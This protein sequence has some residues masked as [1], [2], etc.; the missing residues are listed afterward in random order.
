[1]KF[2][3]KHFLTLQELS[4]DELENLIAGIMDAKKKDYF[5]G[6]EHKTILGFF[7]NHCTYSRLSLESAVK[8]LGGSIVNINFSSEKWNLLHGENTK[9]V[10]R[11][12]AHIKDAAVFL[13][14][15]GDAAAIR[16]LPYSANW[17]YDKQDS[18]LRHITR[19]S[20]IPIINLE[21][22]LYNPLQGLSDV[23]TVREMLKN[24]AG[25]KAGIVWTYH[26]CPHGMGNANEFALAASK[27]GMDLTIS[28]PPGF[29]LDDGILKLAEKNTARHRSFLE[30]SNDLNEAVNGAHVVYAINWRSRKF[31]NN[32][33]EEEQYQKQFENWKIDTEDMEKTDGAYLLHPYPIRRNVCVTDNVLD[34]NISLAEKQIQ[35]KAYVQKFILSEMLSNL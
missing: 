25:W 27:L 26:P 21:S 11:N 29:E 20:S 13:S 28:S 23:I 31:Y 7:P 19:Y 17:N 24:F 35:N 2:R 22:N 4:C 15:C 16:H 34:S 3:T 12:M 30:V 32:R 1:M 14:T 8:Q 5:L 6:L 10:D 9:C 33:Q 18:L